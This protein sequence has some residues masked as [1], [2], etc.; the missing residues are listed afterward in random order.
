MIKKIKRAKSLAKELYQTYEYDAY[1][2][3]Q[4]NPEDRERV[5]FVTLTAIKWTAGHMVRIAICQVRGHDWELWDNGD[6]EN[7][8][9]LMGY[10][11]RCDKGA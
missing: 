3:K 8:P 5:R 6:P 4:Y 1:I 11:K 10:C 2:D 7:G 9:R